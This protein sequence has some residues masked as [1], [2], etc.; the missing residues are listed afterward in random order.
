MEDSVIQG[1]NVDIK[2]LILLIIDK[3]GN[4]SKNRIHSLCYFYSILYRGDIAFQP[5]YFGPYS[6]QIER[7]LDEMVGIGLLNVKYNYHTGYN[8]SI[9]KSGSEIL[10]K[11]RIY[12]SNEVEMIRKFVLNLKEVRGLELSIAAK[13]HYALCK[14]NKPLTITS[15]I[16]KIKERSVGEVSENIITNILELLTSLGLIKKG[17]NIHE[18]CKFY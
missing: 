1:F 4:T 10:E 13:T 18:N 6:T 12:H 7:A 9:N 11:I 5:H 2:D 8:Y 3:L 14:E 17:G 15:V 16:K